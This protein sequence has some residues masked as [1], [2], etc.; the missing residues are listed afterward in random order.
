M[1]CSALNRRPGGP[2]SSRAVGAGGAGRRAG[3]RVPGHALRRRADVRDAAFQL[4]DR[5]FGVRN[6]MSQLEVPSLGVL[7]PEL[8]LESLMSGVQISI[9]QLKNPILQLEN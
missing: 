6:A 1:R 9:S 7:I 4:N 3:R 5:I 8:Q 2:A